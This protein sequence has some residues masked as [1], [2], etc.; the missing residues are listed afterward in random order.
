[1]ASWLIFLLIQVGLIFTGVIVWLFYRLITKNKK[2][3]LALSDR[4]EIIRK[5]TEYLLAFK[6][7]IDLSEKRIK[8]IDKAQIFQGDDDVGFFFKL[9][10][11]IQEQLSEYVKYIE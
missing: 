2:L 7:A 9:L 5:Q 11:D 1:M 8:E 3:E 6:V 4:D 10:K